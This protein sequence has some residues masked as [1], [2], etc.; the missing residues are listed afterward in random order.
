MVAITIGTAAGPDSVMGPFGIALNNTGLRKNNF[1]GTIAP[2]TT[3]DTASGYEIGSLWFVASTSTL[4]VAKVVTASAAVWVTVNSGGG[5]SPGGTNGQIQYNNA[6]V[7]GGF[8]M[9]GD[10]TITTAGVITIA[11]NSVGTLKLVASSVTLAKMADVATSSIFYRKTAGT[12]VPEVQTLATLK[13]DL[14]L[15]GINSGDQTTIA[16]IT[17]TKAQFNT[18][19]TDGDILYVGDIT[20]Y[21]DE[22]A[23]DAIGLMIDGT[24]VYVDA[25]PLLTRAAITGDI[26]IPQ[27]S[28]ASTLA[29]VNA[30]TGSFGLA[31]SVAQFTVNGKGLI[32]TA[33]NVAIS[34]AASAISDSTTAGRAMLTAS[35]ATVQTAL[36]DAFT[37]TTKGLTPASGGGTTNFLRADGTWAA[38][39]G[40]GGVSDGD[41]GDI[42]VSGS[43]TVW[44]LDYAAVNPVIAPV[45]ANNT[46]K[47]TT[48]SGYGITDGVTL[49][50][51]QTVA[52]NKSF[53]GISTLTS[54]ATGLQSIVTAAGTTTLTSASPYQ[55]VFTGTTTQT[56]VLPNAT[57]LGVGHT[58][59]FSNN[60]TGA[61]TVQ[62][63]GG[64]TLW[65]IAGA[66]TDL[67]LILL[68]N[69]TAAGSWERDYRV[70]SSASGKSSTFNNSFI[71]NGT[72]GTTITFPTTS[73]TVARTDAA[74]SFTGIQTFLSEVA[75]PGTT[76]DPASPSAGT[77]WFDSQIHATKV[78]IAGRNRDLIADLANS[79]SMILKAIA[80]GTT[81]TA[82]GTAAPTFTGTATA[83][84]LAVTNRHSR[85]PR[86]E[87]L[88]TVAAT[89]AVAGIRGAASQVT[90]GGASSD[91]GGFKASIVWGPATGVATTTNRGFAGMS[92]AA[93]P[94][95]VEPSTHLNNVGMGWDAADTN[96][97]MMFND[98]SGT[99]T[100]V[101]LGASFPV[102][103]TDRTAMY[104][105]EMYSPKGTT[106]S[107]QWR[108]TDMVS[109][110]VA[111][112]T[113][114]TK[115][116]LNSVMLHPRCWMSVGGTSSVIGV[117]LM[118]FYVDP[119]L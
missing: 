11:N 76:T 91:L 112:G 47:P 51:N 90:I 25:T 106:Q 78:N 20:Q 101:D 14:G 119:L 88:V 21:T 31:G 96:I 83:A 66:S 56:L 15:T 40:G 1:G 18:A 64:A 107:V 39:A 98:A 10:A 68:D 46:S 102:P 36:L 17:G 45:F 41:K 32:T 81:F 12:G 89:T 103:T 82:L 71:F 34:I 30:T 109:G 94:T 37:S 19:V 52:G 3:D 6:G 67:D 54:F 23:Q 72:D 13:A 118:S 22:L 97:Q 86:V 114:T 77:E 100:K 117:A 93:V 70:G 7:F 105:I 104:K 53:T 43:G 61:V 65:I 2:T 99:A 80:G 95:D 33:A 44:S 50:G 73:A 74:Q 60:S 8:T 115:L 42:V 116:P 48:I 38:P 59:K 57:T 84:A 111:Q 113:A 63:N 62:T 4:Y 75:N 24:L 5:G 26:S 110:A 108:V 49:A 69:S 29:T 28:N 79:G 92:A 85:A 58:F 35:T 9:S 27:G 55:T 87:A 16:G